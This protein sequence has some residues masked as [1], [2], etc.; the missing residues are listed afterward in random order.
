MAETYYTKDIF[1]ME[2]HKFIIVCFLSLLII[3]CFISAQNL[4]LHKS[5]SLSTL[6]NYLYSAPPSDHTSLTDGVYTKGTFWTNTTTVGWK[7]TP[8]TVTIDLGKIQPVGAVTFNTCRNNNVGISFPQNIYV[9]TSIDNKNFS[10][11]GD[12]AATADNITGDYEVKKF[13]LSG[14]DVMARYVSLTIV[15]E[16]PYLF[17]DEIEVL[18]GKVNNSNVSRSISKDHIEQVVDSFK[19]IN[20]IRRSLKKE[21]ERIQS[22]SIKESEQY[23]EL[24]NINSQLTK[25]NIPENELKD[26][27]NRIGQEHASSLRTKYNIPFIIEKYNP[28]DSLTE[29]SE[30]R[31]DAGIL[32]YQFSIPKDDVQYGSFVITNCKS[33]AQQFSFKV[34]NPNV[35]IDSIELFDVPYV[36]SSNFKQT[37]DPLI[38]V[39]NVLT[40]EPGISEMFVFKIIGTNIGKAKSVIAVKSGNKEISVNINSQVLDLLTENN[41]DNPNANVWAYLN[42]P[43]LKDRQAEA[44]K[45][46]ELHHINTI[47]IPPQ[48]LPN[49]K[50]V[51]DTQFINY[52]GNFKSIKNILLFMNY[53]SIIDRNG[54]KNGQYMSPAWKNNFIFWYNKMLKLIHD[55]GFSNAQVYLY[56]FDEVDRNNIKYF[57]SLVRWAKKAIPGM[58]FFATL[59]SKESIDSILPLIDIA[60]IPSF[61]NGLKALPPHQCEIW[62]YSTTSSARSL[63][64]YRY[65]RLMAWNAFANDYKGIGFWSYADEGQTKQHNLVSDP[66]PNLETSYSVIYDG[67]GKE[68]ISSRRWEAFRLGIEDYSIL[69]KY[70]KKFGIEKAKMLATQVLSTPEDSNKADTVRNEMLS[71]LI[72]N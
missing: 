34:S 53:T 72:G 4:A 9:L 24:L 39:K 43:L 66:L 27:K 1:I 14:F 38:E 49:L 21:I 23:R 46:L 30:P 13:I 17:V 15:P 6:P 44:A 55:N 57:E 36:A 59:A 42:S 56:P 68:I 71:V 10:Y 47:V 7:S 40:I 25:R 41:I 65:Y 70:A 64:P 20:Y 26:L 32:N 22:A 67:P 50:T 62:I 45:D 11:V 51:D 2:S 48:I 60:Q 31:A 33:S 54:Y 61:D 28:W 58:K 12:A 19:R 5:Y 29:F 3:P 18:K 8:V 37:P 63:S 69:K 35:P 16:G 52:L